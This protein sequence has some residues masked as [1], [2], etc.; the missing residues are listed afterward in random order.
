MRNGQAIWVCRAGRKGEVDDILLRR[1]QIALLFGNVRDASRIPARDG[2]FRDA[3]SRGNPNLGKHAT[4]S[5]AKQ[6]MDLVHTMQEG[7]FCTYPRRTD[8]TCRWG[9]IAGPYMYDPAEK[10]DYAHRRPVRWL[11]SVPRDGLPANELRSVD[12]PPSLYR[13]R[14]CVE[15][16]TARFD[17]PSSTKP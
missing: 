17:A 14:S 13:L 15:E 7:D 3:I 5:W 2:M 12:R 8:R 10:P 9:V 16:W 6:L 1:N 11:A 4:I